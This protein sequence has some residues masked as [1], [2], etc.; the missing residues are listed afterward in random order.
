VLVA[1][2]AV[3]A[4]GIVVGATILQGRA[5]GE[6]SA[7]TNTVRVTPARALFYPDF[8]LPSDL[9]GRAPAEQF[10][11]LQER[12]EQGDVEALLLLGAAY[13]RAGQ[14]GAARGAFDRARA[15]APADLRAQVAA[16][17]GRFTRSNPAAAFSRLGPLA[18]DHPDAAIV[19]FHL[20]VLLLS[21]G[22]G[23]EARAQLRRAAASEPDA[24][25]GR[26]AMT[27][28]SSLES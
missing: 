23:E 7:L 17:V 22:Q 25:Y 11:A 10:A 5:D 21:I 14:P 18:R 3:L 16:A 2:A 26:E 12:G 27:L 15:A 8:G 13:Q 20:G 4:A 24:F 6:P 9:A 19:R 28:L 1:L